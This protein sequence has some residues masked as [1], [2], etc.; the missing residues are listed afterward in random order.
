MESRQKRIQENIQITLREHDKEDGIIGWEITALVDNEAFLVELYSHGPLTSLDNL[1]DYYVFLFSRKISQMRSFTENL[2]KGIGATIEKL[3]NCAENHINSIKPKNIISFINNNIRLIFQDEEYSS[4]E[5]RSVTTDLIGKYISGIS[6]D[7]L[8]YLCKEHRYLIINQFDQFE[9]QLEKNPEL[10]S[11]IYT[12]GHLKEVGPFQAQKTFD[13][14]YHIIKKDKSP[15]K[16]CVKKCISVYAEDV[17]IIYKKISLDDIF[18]NEIIIREF[19]AFLQKIQSPM[20]NTFEEYSKNALELLN[21]HISE[22]GHSFK[23]SIP[24]NAIIDEWSKTENWMMR[25]LRITHDLK[26]VNEKAAYV[27]RLSKAPV[28]NDAFINSVST[29]IPTDD[30]FT[31]S[32]QNALSILDSI[33][34]SK[35]FAILKEPNHLNDYCNLIHSAIIEIADVLNAKGESLDQDIE[36]LFEM[37][38]IISVNISHNSNTLTGICY[39]ASMYLC[40]IS[41]KLLRAVFYYLTK[42]RIYVPLNKVSLGE[43]LSI[44]NTYMLK[45]FSKEHLK[46]LSFFLHQDSISKVGQNLRNSLAHWSNNINCGLMT[47][48]LVAK[49]LWIFT[50]IVNTIFDYCLKIHFRQKRNDEG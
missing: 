29:N 23:Y 2:P 7:A 42:N 34:T 35:L 43:L 3:A 19:T 16:E 36:L 44:N 48:I 12:T 6:I 47:P 25:L 28:N 46:N 17:E 18:Q 37:I 40:A 27:S 32:H 10:F 14:W 41:E 20:A 4:Y 1:D 13:I 24:I 9:K 50:D 22:T 11:Y 49:L 33:E 31:I 8:S 15:L 45:I 30:Y 39:G 5:I 21:K 26:I 38:T